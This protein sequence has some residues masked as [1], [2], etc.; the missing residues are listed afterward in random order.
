MVDSK[1]MCELLLNESHIAVNY[2]GMGLFN[3]IAGD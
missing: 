1:I 2:V 3:N